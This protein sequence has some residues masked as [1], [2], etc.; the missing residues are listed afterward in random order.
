MHSA[1]EE[2]LG[3]FAA[4]LAHA[5]EYRLPVV[6]H[7]REAWEALADT[8]QPWARSVRADYAGEPLGVLH[9][10]SAD[11]ETARRYID[12][13]FLIS[14]HTSVTHPKATQLREV[15]ASL[16][17]D[18]LVVETDSPYGAP[19]AYRGQRNQPAYV[20]EAVGQI[21]RD[22]GE[23]IEAVGSATTANSRRLFGLDAAGRRRRRASSGAAS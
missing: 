18:A 16:P 17:L 3:A 20:I 23:D 11:L 9:Y 19:Q 15:A 5:A 6:I 21:A 22:R 4:Q 10:F 13:G 1:V 14:V 2:Q 12:L 8:L 7:C